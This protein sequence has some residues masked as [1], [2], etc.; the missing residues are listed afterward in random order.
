MEANMIGEAFKFMALGM[1]VVF[2][3]LVIM[4]FT[5]KAQAV[6]IA[7]YFT[8]EVKKSSN[9]SERE[10]KLTTSNSTNTNVVAAVTAAILHHNQK[11]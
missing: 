10:Q 2:T 1:G 5:L 4:I 7:K 9:S 11:N 6:F 3:F 8:K